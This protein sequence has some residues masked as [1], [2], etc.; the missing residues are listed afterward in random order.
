MGYS[1]ARIAVAASVFVCAA[2]CSVLC[3]W[4]CSGLRIAHGRKKGVVMSFKD[5]LNRQEEGLVIVPAAG[6]RIHSGAL[7]GLPKGL[8]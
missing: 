7:I 3:A 2:S 4:L 1:F 6:S 5:G 8:R